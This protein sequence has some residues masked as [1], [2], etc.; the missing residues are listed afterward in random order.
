MIENIWIWVLPVL[1]IWEMIWKGIALWKTAR[2]K[3]LVWFICIFVINTIG[4]LPIIYLVF[5]H[6]KK[7]KK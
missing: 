6:K 7:V 2:C 1:V 3:R 5:F 4:L